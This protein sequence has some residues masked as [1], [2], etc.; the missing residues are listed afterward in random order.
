M[1]RDELAL[2]RGVLAAPDDDLPRLVYADWLDEH[3]GCVVR[4]DPGARHSHEGYRRWIAK[5]PIHGIVHESD[6]RKP[7]HHCDEKC[8]VPDGY[9]A[10]AEFIRVQVELARLEAPVIEARTK[11][12]VYGGCCDRHADMK[13]C[14]C[15]NTP[16]MQV[17]RERERE[18]WHR[19]P[20]RDTFAPW[21]A[22]ISTDPDEP[23]FWLGDQSRPLLAVR[24][25]FVAEV[26]CTFAGW[27][28]HGDELVWSSG[29]TAACPDCKDESPDRAYCTAREKPGRADG[30]PRPCPPTAQPVR[31][32][33]LTDVDRNLG[34][35][36]GEWYWTD[37]LVERLGRPVKLMV[38]YPTRGAA[39]AALSAALSDRWSGVEFELPAGL[40]GALTGCPS[41]NYEPVSTPRRRAG[42]VHGTSA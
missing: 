4:C 1:T 5:Q 34:A 16:E 11:G 19:L 23:R 35:S 42:F 38:T 24:R 10:R 8:R 22:G 41:G 33:R 12:A 14:D 7:H 31:K 2:L 25:G 30:V 39:L 40:P 32:V 9:A 18:L 27:L 28:Y 36:N 13:A 17:L 20:T 37:H 15:L 6:P 26:T 21:A 3:A 29:Q